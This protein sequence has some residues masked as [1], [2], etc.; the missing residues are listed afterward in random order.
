MLPTTELES[1]SDGNDAFGR[2][3]VIGIEGGI[4]SSRMLSLR[5]ELAYARPEIVERAVYYDWGENRTAW[6]PNHNSLLIASTAVVLAPPVGVA[7]V[8]PFGSLG[9][10]AK[11]YRFHA[12][13]G[14]DVVVPFAS[15]QVAPMV[16]AG[17]GVR[18]P[19]L[20]WRLSVEAQSLVSRFERYPDHP[21]STAR[22]QNDMTVS[23]GVEVPLHRR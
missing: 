23:A 14:G 18:F 7:G 4:A 6:V 17:A 9:V 10:G 19:I 2:T 5:A 12:T 16:T 3:G 8:R 22:W 13:S 1:W 15:D 20:S 21:S 11:F